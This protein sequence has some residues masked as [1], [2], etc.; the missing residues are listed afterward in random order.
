MPRT[1]FIRKQL[2]RL[3]LEEGSFSEFLRRVEGATI[4]FRYNSST[5]IIEIDN[6]ELAY[7]KDQDSEI[8]VRIYTDKNQKSFYEGI[9]YT[10]SFNGFI[11]SCKNLIE[12][13]N[14]PIRINRNQMKY[15]RL[16]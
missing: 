15:G 13:L 16:Q 6:V 9:I 1:V 8:N 12:E 11:T 3:I 4:N 2:E 7:F 14:N 5:A 10:R